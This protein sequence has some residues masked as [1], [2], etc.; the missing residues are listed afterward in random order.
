M[1]CINGIYNTRVR[2]DFQNFSEITFI[3]FIFSAEEEYSSDSSGYQNYME[4]LQHQIPIHF[5]ILYLLFWAT[6]FLILYLYINEYLHISDLTPDDYSSYFDHE[7][8]EEYF[9]KMLKAETFRLSSC[10]PEKTLDNLINQ[11]KCL[12]NDYGRL[13]VYDVWYDVNYSNGSLYSSGN[14]IYTVYT[15]VPNLIIRIQQK[16]YSSHQGA[17]LLNTNFGSMSFSDTWI[18]TVLEVLRILSQ[19]DYDFHSSLIILL[20]GGPEYCGLNAFINDHKWFQDVT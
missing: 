13:D 7:N 20:S 8:N 5:G 17:L 11:T 12:F 18:L 14:K 9:E 19:N 4:Y 16:T 6:L 3:C 1:H 15:N 10:E 2:L